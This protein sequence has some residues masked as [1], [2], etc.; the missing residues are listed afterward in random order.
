LRPKK[1][2]NILIIKICCLGDIVFITPMISALKKQYP[3]SKITIVSSN[4]IKNIFQFLDG[5]D[6]VIIFNPYRKNFIAKALAA[7]RLILEIR[8]KKIDL[9]VTTHRNNF[10]GLILSL[11]GIKYRLGFSQTKHLTHTSPFDD[12]IHETKRYLAIL[13]SIGMDSIE[14]ANLVQKKNKSAIRKELGINENDFLLCI[15]PFGGVNPGTKMTIKRWELEKYIS[16]IEKLSAAYPNIKFLIMEGTQPDENF[17]LRQAQGE[18][19]IS[20]LHNVIVKKIN[21][22]I[23][24]VCNIFVA[25]DTGPL[26]IAAAFGV[27]TLAIF[28][29][30]DPNMLA[31]LI[32]SQ[33]SAINKYIWKK[34]VCSPCYTPETA[35]QRDNPKYWRSDTFICNTGTHVCIKEITVEEVFNTLIEMISELIVK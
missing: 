2:K 35:I 33:N 10:F 23:I 30:S 34:P 21:D 6:D 27:S 3:D 14:P 12:T 19:S 25:G 32:N 26:H 15:F 20:Q 4:W 13:K 9:G 24:S 1:V 16:L 22:D 8:K 11:S 7:F 31:P 5:V 18:E 28:G 29:P 17:T